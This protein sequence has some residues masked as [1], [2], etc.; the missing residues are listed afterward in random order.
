MS[1][2]QSNRRTKQPVV[3]QCRDT[4]CSRVGQKFSSSRGYRVHCSTY[5]NRVEYS[6][7]SDDSY[8]SDNIGDSGENANSDDNSNASPS[9]THS[10][11]IPAPPLP[12][13][14][15]ANA[16]GTFPAEDISINDSDES[17]PGSSSLRITSPNNANA[18]TLRL[19]EMLQVSGSRGAPAVP[20]G[21]LDDNNEVE[22]NDEG[23][24]ESVVSECSDESTALQYLE[25]RRQLRPRGSG[26]VP[27]TSH[28]DT[29]EEEGIAAS[30]SVGV[31]TPA[32]DVEQNST[33]AAATAAEHNPYFLIQRKEQVDKVSNDSF[34]QWFKASSLTPSQKIELRSLFY[35]TEV[36]TPH[37]L[38][39]TMCTQMIN[40]VF[41]ISPKHAHD[42]SFRSRKVFVEEVCSFNGGADLLPKK[43][44]V[45]LKNQNVTVELVTHDASAW[46]HSLL[47]DPALMVDGNMLFPGDS[48]SADIFVDPNT[49]DEEYYGD[50]TTGSA[51]REAYSH[52][53]NPDEGNN[54]L[55]PILTFADK[56]HTDGLGNLTIEGVTFTLGIF[57]R[58][59]RFH[60]R[61]HGI[62]G[63][64]PSRSRI[65]KM[66]GD[67]ISPSQRC[68]DVH[69][70]LTVIWQSYADQF[71]KKFF[72][73]DLNYRGQEYRVKFF[74]YIQLLGGDSEGQD[75]HLGRYVARSAGIQSPCRMCKVTT[76]NLSNP[77]EE[78]AYKTQE[79]IITIVSRKN[80]DRC[81][82]VSHHPFIPAYASLDV[83]PGS[84]RGMFAATPGEVLHMVNRGIQ[85]RVF[86]AL[87]DEKKA[88]RNTRERQEYDRVEAVYSK[89]GA[90][91][92]D[93]KSQKNRSS[94]LNQPY[95][96]FTETACW[97][98]D[99]HAS[100]IGN[101]LNQQSDRNKPRTRFSSRFT[102][103]AKKTAGEMTGV[104]LVFVMFLVSSEG[105]KF[106]NQYRMDALS[107]AAYIQ[108]IELLLML[109]QMFHCPRLPVEYVKGKMR[110]HVSIFR[111]LLNRTLGR[112]EG[113][114][115][116]FLKN[117]LVSHVTDDTQIH[118]VPRN[119]GGG[120]GE[121]RHSDFA[122]KPGKRTQRR[123][124]LFDYQTSVRLT[125]T[126]L[127]NIFVDRLFLWYADNLDVDDPNIPGPSAYLSLQL[128]N[129]RYLLS[130]D[131]KS[132][133]TR[134]K[135]SNQFCTVH[136]FGSESIPNI[137]ET[138]GSD[139]SQ[140]TNM[141]I[142]FEEKRWRKRKTSSQQIWPDE[143]QQQR[144]GLFIQSLIRE[145]YDHL[146]VD[147]N[148]NDV[149][150]PATSVDLYG[151]AAVKSKTEDEPEHFDM[152]GKPRSHLLFYANPLVGKHDWANI[153]WGEN[154]GSVPAHLITYVDL[155]SIPSG[156][157]AYPPGRYA[158]LE[159]MLGP[160]PENNMEYVWSEDNPSKIGL[161][162][163][164]S[165]LLYYGTK[166]LENGDSV[167]EADRIPQMF[168]VPLES[169]DSECIAIPDIGAPPELR[170]A[171]IFL[172][173]MSSWPMRFG[174]AIESMPS[175][176]GSIPLSLSSSSD[177]DL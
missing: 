113:M 168:C 98:L 114:G 10:P 161:I 104:L 159:S 18:R 148:D 25:F 82:A 106:C 40:T 137:A 129:N 150:V 1:E 160:V 79:D 127:I 72:Y 73:W 49:I 140:H 143:V 146:V 83:L 91:G 165:R 20:T 170:D 23:E 151:L 109:E 126:R 174:Q 22:D 135:L 30:S 175:A 29:N 108:T 96:V 63:Y 84:Q 4:R 6:S 15:V 17:Y 55:L 66:G 36:N 173:P 45:K 64:L 80:K 41:D 111:D 27:I 116:D 119:Y 76:D 115:M 3:Y 14:N 99:R 35:T 59:T 61:S 48:S 139:D 26:T 90:Q 164:S 86:E 28:D 24:I 88:P 122:K 117:H 110:E 42:I 9:N 13:P 167:G 155:R 2:Q 53:C 128:H 60:S 33:V 144:V 131:N 154:D 16:A 62:L 95:R 21:V 70:M 142:V 156:H 169:I 7:H 32:P 93:G 145:I 163:D 8:S 75:Y 57:N 74:P 81:K 132:N 52:L 134:Y 138:S 130:N 123:H 101:H 39:A 125:E 97:E 166:V 171:Y 34:K 5:H 107:Q 50:I 65:E 71:D 118:G 77:Y 112:T 172:P 147:N 44:P 54:L 105:H 46:M 176:D 68:E 103:N 31:P 92:K 56:T 12:D 69:Q 85:D 120:P 121:H 157:P 51:Y 58:E 37:S 38:Y 11:M 124:M 47:T 133:G 102:S 162:H 100:I 43:I 94:L 19:I 89:S 67:K 158:L 136:F 153:D 152:E 149:D 141:G 87:M 177:S 78:F